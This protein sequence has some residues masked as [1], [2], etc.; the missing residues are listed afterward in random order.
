LRKQIRPY[1]LNDNDVELLG[2]L[3][4]HGVYLWKNNITLNQEQFHDRRDLLKESIR[5]HLI[6]EQGRLCAYCG[7]SIREHT[8]AIEHIA[9][10]SKPKYRHVMFNP[11]NLVLACG[12]CNGAKGIQDAASSWTGDYSSW[13]FLIVHPILDNPS[14]HIEF[15]PDFVVITNV[16]TTKGQKT[17]DWFHLQKE[18]ML[19]E[20]LRHFKASQN[21]VSP[22]M[23]DLIQQSISIPRV[24]SR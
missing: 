21:L 17:I 22:E 14:D 19:N 9:D 23:E 6:T 8:P 7:L 2:V 15:D 20:R 11:L 24:R 1:L 4:A 10:K 3:E 16:H 18:V 12:T 13:S 5:E